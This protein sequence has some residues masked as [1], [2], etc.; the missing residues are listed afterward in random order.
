MHSNFVPLCEN[1]PLMYSICYRFNVIEISLITKII[2]MDNTIII[3]LQ[4]AAS[5]I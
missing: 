4:N 2:P 5:T 1:I 3:A